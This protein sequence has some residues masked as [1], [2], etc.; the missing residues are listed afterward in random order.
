MTIIEAA[1]NGNSV[2]GNFIGTDATGLGTLAGTGI[3]VDVVRGV[4]T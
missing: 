4:N 3:G 1:A 2:Q